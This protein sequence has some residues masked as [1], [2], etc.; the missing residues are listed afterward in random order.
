MAETKVVESL[1][2]AIRKIIDEGRRV[3]SVAANTVLVQQN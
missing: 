2:R 1:Y 3:V